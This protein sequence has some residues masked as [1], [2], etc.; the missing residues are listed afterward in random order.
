[1]R[2]RNFC[3]RHWCFINHGDAGSR[4]DHA[5]SETGAGSSCARASRRRR[6]GA[7]GRSLV[8][9]VAGRVVGRCGPCGRVSGGVE[10][11]SAAMGDRRPPAQHQMRRRL[12]PVH[13]FR[14]GR[15]N[16][17][18]G[19]TRL[20]PGRQPEL[21]RVFPSARRALNSMAKP[22]SRWRT[23]RPLVVPIVTLAPMA[24]RTLLETAAPESE[25]SMMRTW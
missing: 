2:T 24:G 22:P 7:R 23:T 9:C 12:S 25:R 20:R 8:R 17:K 21:W 13:Q 1:M 14:S 18:A 3:C 6:S 10:R 5:A 16:A 15:K 19:R 11:L 4:A